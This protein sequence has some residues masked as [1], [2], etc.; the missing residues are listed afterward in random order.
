MSCSEQSRG[1][2]MGEFVH[3]LIEVASDCAASLVSTLEGLNR[4]AVPVLF[5]TPNG[6]HS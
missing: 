2:L 6:V 4:L 3:N 1:C 5:N